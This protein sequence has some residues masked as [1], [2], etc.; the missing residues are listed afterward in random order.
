MANSSPIATGELYTADDINAL[1]DDVLNGHTHDG[2]DGVKVPFN[3]LNVSGAAGS[4]RPA[5]GNVSYDEIEAHISVSQGVHGTSANSYIASG[6][7]PGMF[8]QGRNDNL[9]SYVPPNTG[10]VQKT[11]Q[12]PVAYTAIPIVICSWGVS[13]RNVSTTQF[14]A[15]SDDNN[16]NQAFTWFAL[17][18]KLT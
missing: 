3:N 13:A 2:T 1:R 14:T 6:E 12:F 18:Q 9:G 15:E 17:G 4:T 8:V 10:L 5:G 7:L 11:V 16:I